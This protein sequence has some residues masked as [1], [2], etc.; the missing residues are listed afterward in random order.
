MINI[1]YH[2]DVS[3]LEIGDVHLNTCLNCYTQTLADTIGINL[4]VVK[5]LKPELTMYV[6][7]YQHSVQSTLGLIHHCN[8]YALY[9]I[10][11]AL[12]TTIIMQLPLT[13][14]HILHVQE[15]INTII[16]IKMS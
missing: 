10:Q 6:V 8:Y 7:S 9:N 1:I 5:G 11:H 15:I 12:A 3:S 2:K 16:V 13:N 4:S 14:I